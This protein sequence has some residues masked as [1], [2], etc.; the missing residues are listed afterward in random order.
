MMTSAER[1][2][3]VAAA[4]IVMKWSPRW[5]SKNTGDLEIQ[6]AWVQAEEVSRVR[7]G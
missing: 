4:S 2:A 6:P 7:D 1:P 3:V 5:T